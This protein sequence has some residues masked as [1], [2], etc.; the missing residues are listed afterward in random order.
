MP[1]RVPLNVVN[2]NDLATTG[3]AELDDDMEPRVSVCVDDVVVAGFL[4]K[5]GCQVN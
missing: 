4:N 5:L 3:V 1:S 2:I